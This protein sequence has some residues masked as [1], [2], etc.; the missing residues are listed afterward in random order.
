M[1]RFDRS[2]LRD[3]EARNDLLELIEQ[4][5]GAI[6]P[7][8]LVR[9]AVAEVLEA[10]PPLPGLEVDSSIYG[11][12]IGK[13]A[14]GMSLGLHDVLGE[15]LT[16]GIAVMPHGMGRDLP[17]MECVEA[18]HPVPDAG[19]LRAAQAMG[20]LADRAGSN[21]TVFCLLSGGG[22]AL[23]P[24]PP[25]GVS[26]RDLA[27]VTRFLLG[28]GAPIDEVNTVRRHLS[29]LQGGQLARR[30]HP[31]RAATLILSDVVSGRIEA[32][33]SGPMVADPS[34]F[35][36]AHRVLREHGL[37]QRVPNAVRT[38]IERG[39]GGEVPETAKPGDPVFERQIVH[40]LA[41]NAGF[42]EAVAQRAASSGYEVV[43]WPE[44]ITGEARDA[45]E[46]IG[47]E[48]ARLAADAAVPMLWVG[49]G[50]TTVTVRG[51]GIGGRNQEVALAAAREIRG[52]GGVH[53]LS[54]ATD[55]VDGPTDAAGALVDGETIDR[56]QEAGIEPEEALQ[57][58]NAYAALAA[59]GDL[60]RSG[61]SGTNVADLVVAAIDRG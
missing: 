12:A 40:M 11:L 27:A 57:E 2:V 33:A 36:D 45:G 29:T 58:N 16:G 50:E 10:L 7:R 31:A 5:V 37:W 30:I 60:L 4:A 14:A 3:A 42:V 51:N 47:R 22:S 34:T 52:L 61:P 38:W 56:M 17:R 49:G 43:R 55:G 19:G 1:Q 35:S 20:K 24:S 6:D 26:L 21:D 13:A 41:D 18:N 23:F 25:A 48:I 8:T 59:S 54:L 9:D 53:I 28:S 15:R 39:C 32:I 46:R 44:A